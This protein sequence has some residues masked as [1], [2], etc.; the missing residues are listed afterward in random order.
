MRN[1][2][3]T[4]DEILIGLRRPNDR[5]V[6]LAID[7]LISEKRIGSEPTTI[8]DKSDNH[9]SS[10]ATSCARSRGVDSQAKTKPHQHC[11]HHGLCWMQFEMTPRIRFV[12]PLLCVLPASA[13]DWKL[14]WSDEFNGPGLDSTKWT[15]ITGGN[16]FGNHEMEYYTARAENLRVENRMLVLRAVKEDY[17]GPDGVQRSYTSGRIHTQGKFA[18]QYGRFEARIKIPTG[19]GMWPAFWMMGA[20]SERWPDRGEIDIMENIGKEPGTVH[21]TI[22]GP[23]YSGAKGIGGPF[24]LAAGKKVA[25]DFH[26]YAVEWTPDEI[27]WYVDDT[28]YKT[29][30]PANLSAGAKWVFD[31]P[32]YL[33]LN[34]AVGGDWPGSPDDAA[35]AFP[36]SMLVDY[37]RVYEQQ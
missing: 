35:T 3:R 9:F 24:S 17:T 13:S 15:A 36:Q 6:N 11:A 21:G 37:V 23:G 7:F 29:A 4:Y 33:L 18:Q 19:Q 12:A 22:H 25:D 32:F 2:K 14:V 5:I 20:N 27:R 28:L 31:G 26:I 10:V 30:T 16:G 1:E 34:F 8:A